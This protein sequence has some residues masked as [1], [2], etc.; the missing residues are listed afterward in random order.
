MVSVVVIRV[1]DPPIWCAPSIAVAFFYCLFLPSFLPF[2]PVPA[3]TIKRFLAALSIWRVFTRRPLVTEV[4]IHLVF[5]DAV[6]DERCLYCQVCIL[7]FSLI[8]WVVKKKIIF[9]M[10]NTSNDCVYPP[11][12]I[13]PIY[14]LPL[15]F[16]ILQTFHLMVYFI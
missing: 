9:S 13:S 3:I 14:S 16:W 11:I 8:N 12:T 6:V 10:E 5:P 7:F 2:F 4:Q 15:L 1:S